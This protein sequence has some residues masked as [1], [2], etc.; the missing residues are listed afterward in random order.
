MQQLHEYL[1]KA[2]NSVGIAWGTLLTAIN[3]ILFPDRAYAYAAFALGFAVIVDIF[4]K[5]V[6]ITSRHGGLK[7][8]FRMGKLFS[9]TL[10]KGTKV[11]LQAYLSI[12]IMVGLSYRLNSL[13]GAF[14]SVSIFMATVVYTVLFLREFQSILENFRD[15]GAKN[16]EWLLIWSRS[17]EN[18]I[19]KQNNIKVS[20]SESIDEQKIDELRKCDKKVEDTEKWEDLI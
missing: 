4:S 3:F 16:V 13:P 11:K 18:E 20:G 10:W 14:T 2:M 9:K 8:S 5:Y 1:S 12:S 17:K 19:F 15:A 6:A 7:K